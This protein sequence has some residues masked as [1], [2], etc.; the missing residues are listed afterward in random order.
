[1]NPD[2]RDA[3]SRLHPGRA[4]IVQSLQG[5]FIGVLV[6]TTTGPEGAR[7]QTR[8]QPIAF[9]GSTLGMTLQDWRAVPI[10]L[11]A[12]PA[13]ERAC[14]NEHR[15]AKIPAFHLSAIEVKTGVIACTYVSRFGHQVLAHSIDLDPSF[16]ASNLAFVF[17]HNRLSEIRF[18]ASIDARSDIIALLTK[19]YG[20]P[21][22]TTHNSS[23][24]PWGL[25]HRVR[26]SWTTPTGIIM[27]EDPSDQLTLLSV[28]MATTG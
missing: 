2:R 8:A 28:R 11:G 15:I 21:T 26:Q 5:I 23:W 3:A 9:K 16:R 14:S 19:S 17:T 24:M 4:G 25:I 1:M 13:P 12:G 7:G 10:P 22:R 6:C 18:K 27:L 20:P